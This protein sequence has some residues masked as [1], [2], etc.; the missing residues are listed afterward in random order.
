MKMFS[1]A[2][3]IT[4]FFCVMTKQTFGTQIDVIKQVTYL[5]IVI[6]TICLY[7]KL[8]KNLQA[9]LNTSFSKK[10]WNYERRNLIK[11]ITL[12][13]NS[14]NLGESPEYHNTALDCW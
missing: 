6:D 4:V 13:F 7:R 11:Y 3:K 14:N 10:L 9:W 2:T 12:K 5:S 8:E 1:L